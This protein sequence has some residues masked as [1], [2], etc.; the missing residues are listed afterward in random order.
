MRAGPW[1]LR[2]LALLLF[3]V[4]APVL[5]YSARRSP[6]RA[7]RQRPGTRATACAAAGAALLA[8]LLA[9]GCGKLSGRGDSEGEESKRRTVLATEY[10]DVRVGEEAAEDVAAE[11]GMVEDPELTAYLNEIGERLLVHAPERAFSYRFAVVDQ[12]EP[13]AFALPGGYI[14]VSRGAIAL[15][16]DEDEL[17]N[18]IGHEI[19]H[20]AERHA[21]ARQMVAQRQSALLMP[22]MR[23]AQLAAYSRDQERSADRGGQRMAAATGYD[24]AGM[25]RFLDQLRDFS[26][27]DFSYS[28]FPPFFATH[29]GTTERVTDA[30]VRAQ[31]LSYERTDATRGDRSAYLKRIEGVM[32]GPN[33]AEGVFEG[34]NFIHPDMGFRIRFPEGWD[35]ENGRHA[36]GATAPDGGGRIFLAL[37][38]PGSRDAEMAAEAFVAR[39]QRDLQLSVE[40]ARPVQI[41]SAA[42]FRIEGRGVIEG[43]AVAT[44]ITF[45]PFNSLMFRLTATAPGRSAREH[46]GWGRIT[47]RSFRAL[48]PTERHSV[49]MLQVHVVA[50]EPDEDLAALSQ[51]AGNAYEVR[52][53]AVLNGIRP[54]TR[55]RGG[56]WVKIARASPYQ[57]QPI[58]TAQRPELKADPNPADP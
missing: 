12:P 32:L 57:P 34:S 5:R 25:A 26:R 40:R 30:A 13:N 23:I 41:G 16:N 17:A 15:A 28:Q 6:P 21:A 20:A 7:R 33:P 18:V 36:V 54:E 29:P 14:Y 44:E 2:G 52:R 27:L 9:M 50:A 49:S 45:I 56:E 47:A 46:L 19:M 55:F 42:G 4:F 10:D 35:L 22:L 53:T 43:A 38:P 39:T 24:P 37:E 1:T 58:E 51:R 8:G 3:S 11:L 48:T 31:S